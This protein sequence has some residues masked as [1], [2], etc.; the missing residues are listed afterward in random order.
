[1][2]EIMSKVIH[3]N[4]NQIAFIHCHNYYIGFSTMPSWKGV[5]CLPVN[6]QIIQ[7]L[8]NITLEECVH[9]KQ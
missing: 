2:K 4:L 5:T 3:K 7:S 8:K 6:V 9:C 1:M